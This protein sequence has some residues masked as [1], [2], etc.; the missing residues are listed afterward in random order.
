[1]ALPVFSFGTVSPTKAMVSAIMMAAPTPCTAL[2]AISSP[3]VGAAPHRAEPSVN[4]AIPPRSTPTADDVAEATDADDQGR[5]G[6]E[7]G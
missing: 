2:A 7:I 6:E 1:M 4:S 5:D 3:S